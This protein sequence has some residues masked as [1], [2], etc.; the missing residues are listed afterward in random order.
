MCGV[1]SKTVVDLVQR[2]PQLGP[3]PSQR[4]S[5]GATYPLL[6]WR[7]SRVALVNKSDLLAAL[8]LALPFVVSPAV[9]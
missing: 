3:D 8:H 2:Y 9:L 4:F 6:Q 1:N 5:L 7:A